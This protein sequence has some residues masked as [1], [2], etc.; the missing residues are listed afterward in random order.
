MKKIILFLFL[1][2]CAF[3]EVEIPEPV[4]TTAQFQADPEPCFAK[5][6]AGGCEIYDPT[7]DKT[8]IL[9]KVEE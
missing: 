6:A 2:G 9:R 5:A 7:L 1:S 3:I 8:F 4:L